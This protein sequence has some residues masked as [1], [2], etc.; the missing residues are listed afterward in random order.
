MDNFLV[1]KLLC[2]RYTGNGPTSWSMLIGPIFFS[3][4]LS[5]S[6][7]PYQPNGVKGGRKFTVDLPPE[8]VRYQVKSYMLLTL[9]AYLDIRRSA[10]GNGPDGERADTVEP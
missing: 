1:M 8:E 10:G 7:Y 5:L 6:G 2:E 4:L 9:R 3:S